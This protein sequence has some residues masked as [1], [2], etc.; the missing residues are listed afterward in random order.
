LKDLF[1]GIQNKS[2][3]KLYSKRVTWWVSCD[4]RL[5]W[6]INNRIVGWPR[7][8]T[9][10]QIFQ[11]VT[12]SQSWCQCPSYFGGKNLIDVMVAINV[13]V[14]PA[15]LLHIGVW[16]CLGFVNLNILWFLVQIFRHKNKM[17]ASVYWKYTHRFIL[18]ILI[19]LLLHYLHS[20]HQTSRF[21]KHG[22]NILQRKAVI[23]HNHI[24][25]APS[26]II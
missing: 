22:I 2:I 10:K 4:S 5:L 7:P 16:L 23:L 6:N 15:A 1:F 9:I 12:L 19:L 17:S 14:V 24:K 21:H 8:P 3:K 18:H 25:P 20:N 26:H 11:Y 13:T